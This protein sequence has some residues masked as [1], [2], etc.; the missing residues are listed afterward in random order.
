[1]ASSEA[2]ERLLSKLTKPKK[3]QNHTLLGG[4]SGES[5]CVP[6]GSVVQTLM[7]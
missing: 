3:G 5:I 7:Y 6:G 1:M 2:V 4:P